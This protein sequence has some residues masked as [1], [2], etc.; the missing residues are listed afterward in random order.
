MQPVN[1]ILNY[2]IA[3][4]IQC[5]YLKR[6]DSCAGPNVICSQ[7]A[8]SSP[9]PAQESKLIRA[10]WVERATNF[11]APERWS[12]SCH[13]DVGDVFFDAFDH[14]L[15]RSISHHFGRV[16]SYIGAH[17]SGISLFLV[18]GLNFWHRVLLFPCILANY[19]L[20]TH[21][22][23]W[24]PLIRLH[25]F[26]FHRPLPSDVNFVKVPLWTLKTGSK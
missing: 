19:L 4:T 13:G 22:G 15:P 16:F 1:S 18:F 17:L 23:R 7:F 24:Y 12:L 9:N 10:M 14:L 6:K 2:F 11:L 26:T 21:P 25:S 3:N 5:L 20:W 8:P